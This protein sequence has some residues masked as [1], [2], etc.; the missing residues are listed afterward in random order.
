ML[1]SVV[2]PR[3]APSAA[4]AVERMPYVALWVDMWTAVMQRGAASEAQAMLSAGDTESD[5]WGCM[6]FV[7]DAVGE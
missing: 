2:V 1:A 3:T 4:L 6:R 7:H 5:E